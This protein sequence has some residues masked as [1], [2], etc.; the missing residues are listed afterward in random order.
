MKD[1][2]ISIEQYN[3]LRILKGQNRT[4]ITINGI[5]DRMLDKM[6]NAS[7]LVDKLYF[8]GLVDRRQKETNRRA[9]D[10]TITPKG[11]EVLNAIS[12]ALADRVENHLDMDNADLEQLN[13]LLDK[14]RGKIM[15]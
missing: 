8:K 4:P 14:F 3:V 2:D 11:E 9:C 5:I 15:K 1:F 6:S 12:Q 10:V 13:A 7:R